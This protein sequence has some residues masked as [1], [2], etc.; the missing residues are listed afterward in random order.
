MQEITL[1][2]ELIMPL[3]IGAIVARYISAVAHPLLREICGTEVRAAFWSRVTTV[4]VLL[5]PVALTLGFAGEAGSISS[6][7]RRT[8]VLAIV[9]TLIATGAVARAMFR[10]VPTNGSVTGTKVPS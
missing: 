7:L 3:T 9:G 4:A 5:V 8:L 2:L 1:A 6:V 10:T